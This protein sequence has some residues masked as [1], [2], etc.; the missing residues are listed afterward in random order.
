LPAWRVKQVL[1]RSSHRTTYPLSLVA[2]EIW[3]NLVGPVALLRSRLRALRIGRGKPALLQ[4]ALPQA[5]PTASRVM[6]E[7]ET[8][9]RAS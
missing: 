4:S 1:A 5:A 9:A 7:S 6:A 3:G 2:L 8:S